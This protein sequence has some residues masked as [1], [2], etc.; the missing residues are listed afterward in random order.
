MEDRHKKDRRKKDRDS[1]VIIKKFHIKYEKIYIHLDPVQLPDAQTVE[2]RHGCPLANAEQ[3][4]KPF[5][6]TVLGQH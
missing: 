1:Q 4:A 5:I 3:Y 2:F 6:T